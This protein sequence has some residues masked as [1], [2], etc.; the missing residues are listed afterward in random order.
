[1]KHTMNPMKTATTTLIAATFCF[2]ALAKPNLVVETSVTEARSQGG[3][4][5]LVVPK[6]VVESGKH[7]MVRVGKME[8]ELTPT[9]REDGVVEIQVNWT[10]HDGRESDRLAAPRVKTKVG[11][12]AEIE[13]G[14]F[15]FS[16]KVSPVQ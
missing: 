7:A 14:A 2:S 12:V 1:M 10:E 13:V 15:R 8:W 11:E 3:P 16:T 9:L 5:V 6:I 4:D